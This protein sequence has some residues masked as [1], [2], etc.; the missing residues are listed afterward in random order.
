MEK[1]IPRAF[2]LNLLQMDPMYPLNSQ[3]WSLF[4]SSCSFRTLFHKSSRSSL[5]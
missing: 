4:H 1:Q 2:H 5:L 3:E